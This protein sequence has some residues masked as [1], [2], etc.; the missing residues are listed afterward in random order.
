MA[1]SP[2]MAA[3][4]QI[5]DEKGIDRDIIIETIESAVA[6]AYRKDY[7]HP[8]DV[9]RAK[10]D[11]D[12]EKM[13]I[14]SVVTVVADEEVENS[15]SQISLTEAKE[16]NKK[17]E[18]GDEIIT[19]L[20]PKEEFGRI[21]AQTAKQV[22]V[23]RIREAERD[24]LYQEFKEKE[25]RVVAGSVQ[26]VEGDT[27]LINLGKMNGLL[28]PSDQIP[29]EPYRVGQRLKVMVTGVEETLRGP[30][31]LVSRTHPELIGQ[32]FAQEVPEIQS[33]SVVIK[34]IA[35]EAGNRTKIAVS[36]TQAGVD[37]V[38]SAVGQRGARVQAV[39]AELSGE[40]IDIIPWD[41][42]EVKFITN[43]LSPAQVEKVKLFADIRKALVSVPE[44]QLSLAIGKAGQNV[45]LASHL[46][47]WS[48]DIARAGDEEAKMKEMQVRLGEDVKVESTE[49]PSAD[50]DAEAKSKKTKKAPS[51]AAKAKKEPAKKPAK[52]TTKKAEK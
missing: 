30:R 18:I 36:E 9:I 46:T 38:G 48:I 11:D 52:K 43:A 41:E 3:V 17:A 15:H 51:K 22:I 45:R 44:D 37:P 13:K 24:M 49:K 8:E 26:Q 2:L 23:Q 5:A 19:D 42:D 12:S 47:G 34:A 50:A 14:S 28:L 16:A 39:L 40:K 32:L 33:G 20:E 29:G 25:H 1:I 4:N 27:V 35:R 21:A 31:V 10:F 7:G 6:A